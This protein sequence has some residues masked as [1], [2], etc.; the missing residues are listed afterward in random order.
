MGYPV[1]QG[2]R[3]HGRIILIFGRMLGLDVGDAAMVCRRPGRR[4][5]AGRASE[6]P[7]AGIYRS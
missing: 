1:G 5:F 6:S 7:V 4:Y 3:W 2:S